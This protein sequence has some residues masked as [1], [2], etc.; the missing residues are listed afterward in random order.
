MAKVIQD[1]FI[2][3]EAQNGVGAVFERAGELEG[4]IECYSTSRKYAE[5]NYDLQNLAKAHNAFGRIYNQQ[6][7]YLKAV[8]NKEKS[9][10]LFEKINDLPE[11]AKAYTSLALTYY[12]MG[13]LEKAAMAISGVVSHSS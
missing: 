4:A 10:A 11:L 13:E 8:E 5:E 2:A 7:N 3:A 6:G 9:I 1:Y 12:D